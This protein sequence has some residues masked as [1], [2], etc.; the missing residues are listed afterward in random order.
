MLNIIKKILNLQY[1]TSKT[2]QFLSEYNKTHTLLSSSQQA[3]KRKYNRIFSLRDNKTESEKNTDFWSKF[4]VCF[5]KNLIAK[6]IPFILVGMAIV[7]FSFGIILF[8]YLILIGT[9]VGAVLFFIQWIKIKIFQKK[10]VKSSTKAKKG[11]IIN[12][13]DWRRL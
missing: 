8:I 5:M 4:Q 13:D 1:Y 10:H 2:D 3:E 7:A 11:R 6:L 12:S 9:A